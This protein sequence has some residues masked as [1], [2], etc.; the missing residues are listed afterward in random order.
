MI[1]ETSPD[2][3]EVE[4]LRGARLVGMHITPPA[5]T[6]RVRLAVGWIVGA[7][8]SIAGTLVSYKLDFPTGATMAATLVLALFPS[9]GAAASV[10]PAA[11]RRS[12]SR[13]DPHAA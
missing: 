11:P 1:A 12:P 13:H 5:L 7:A 9:V 3:R 8:V 2:S 4:V 10:A 6:R